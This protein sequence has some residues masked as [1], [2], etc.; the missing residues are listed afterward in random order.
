MNPWE[1][2]KYETYRKLFN[3]KILQF[4]APRFDVHVTIL[5]LEQ[6]VTALIFPSMIY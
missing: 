1:H 5:W 4:R 2:I 3:S 6:Y